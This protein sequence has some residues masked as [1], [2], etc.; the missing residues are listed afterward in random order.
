[1]DAPDLTDDLL[2]TLTKSCPDLN[3][4]GLRRVSRLRNESILAAAICS[5]FGL[6]W[7]E[8]TDCAIVTDSFV[9]MLVTSCPSLGRVVLDRCSRISN[10]AVKALLSLRRL[11]T[12]SLCGCVALTHAAFEKLPKVCPSLTDLSVAFCAAVGDD[13]LQHCTKL[14]SLDISY[15]RIGDKAIKDLKKAAALRNLQ[16]A[17][18]RFGGGNFDVLPRSLEML[19]LAGC[20]GIK[21][22]SFNKLGQRCV[23]L[24]TLI[25]SDSGV[26]DA[27]LQKL[28]QARAFPQLRQLQVARCQ[29]LSDAGFQGAAAVWPNLQRVLASGCWFITRGL[30]LPRSCQLVLE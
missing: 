16:C 9:S 1:M 14:V 18:C 10:V 27:V 22:K 26:T 23:A 3:G 2:E 25:L 24:R 11:S 20:T 17:G 8:L 12:L 30:V 29:A 21:P 19:N 6:L 13:L 28:V 4:I 5:R 15:T 7:L